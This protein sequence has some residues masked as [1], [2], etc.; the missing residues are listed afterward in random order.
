MV[1]LHGFLQVDLRPFDALLAT[2]DV[3]DVQVGEG[4]LVVG[5]F[6]LEDILRRFAL[7]LKEVARAL[8]AADAPRVT[9]AFVDMGR[10]HHG[11]VLTHQHDA[12]VGYCRLGKGIG[13]G[14]I[15]IDT[16]FRL[17]LCLQGGEGQ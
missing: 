9:V 12:H 11:G 17:P 6:E 13:Y 10:V 14:S 8:P 15:H 16:V 2:A 3:L 4:R 7:Y 5:V 1:G